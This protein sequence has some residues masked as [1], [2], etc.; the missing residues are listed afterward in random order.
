MPRTGHD[1]VV[2]LGRQEPA[3]LRGHSAAWHCTVAATGWDV[4]GAGSWN[5]SPEDARSDFHRTL[6]DPE[7]FQFCC[8]PGL[9]ARDS[10]S[11]SA[12]LQQPAETVQLWVHLEKRVLGEGEPNAKGN[13]VTAAI[14]EPLTARRWRG[15]R[16]YS[17]WHNTRGSG[18][19]S[20][21]QRCPNHGGGWSPPNLVFFGGDGAGAGFWAPAEDGTLARASGGGRRGH[22]RG[23]AGGEGPPGRAARAAPAMRAFPSAVARAT[24]SAEPEE[25]WG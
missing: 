24:A 2:S 20:T 9:P 22:A 14:A 25:P 17:A 4:G 3:A 11:S 23:S 7:S 5:T 6:G 18:G 13:R 16:S 19:S 10:P 12:S 1:E 8:S 21:Q 15:Q